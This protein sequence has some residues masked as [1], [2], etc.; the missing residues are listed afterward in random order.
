MTIGSIWLV[1]LLLLLGACQCVFS[2]SQDKTPTSFSYDNHK[3]LRVKP[4]TDADI[5]M[6]KSLQTLDVHRGPL[7]KDA[8]V[9]LM[10]SQEDFLHLTRN[11]PLL[12]IEVLVE[13]V[14]TLI[15]DHKRELETVNDRWMA[16]IGSRESGP[17]VTEVF[18]D[19]YRTL[20]EVDTYVTCTHIIL[21]FFSIYK[22]VFILYLCLILLYFYFTVSTF[23]NLSFYCIRI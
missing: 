5:A 7:K 3:I 15:D 2:I 1:L 21:D 6:I 9:E 11:Q 17:P 4:H 8:T 14:Q 22:Y 13:N 12:S 10:V 23:S 18:F 16:A 20:A 19:T